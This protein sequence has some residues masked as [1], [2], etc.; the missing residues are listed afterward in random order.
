MDRRLFLTGIGGG[1]AGTLTGVHAAE[2]NVPASKALLSTYVTNVA[3][4][5]GTDPVPV[6]RNAPLALTRVNNRAYDANTIAVA[7]SKGRVIGYL[8]TNQSRIMAPLLDAGM[9]A[10]ARVADVKNYPRPAVRI[11]IALSPAS[12]A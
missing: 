3:D 11:E 2:K 1:L 10:S 6:G 5:L 8:P 12:S 4:F 7:T 9:Q